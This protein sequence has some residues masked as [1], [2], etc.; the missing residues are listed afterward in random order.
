MSVKKNLTYNSKDVHAATGQTTNEARTKINL[1]RN[2]RFLSMQ[3]HTDDF[4]W[5]KGRE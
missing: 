4:S 1:S 5:I 2:C 3:R